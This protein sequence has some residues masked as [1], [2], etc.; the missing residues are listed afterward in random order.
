MKSTTHAET[1]AGKQIFRREDSDHRRRVS[2]MC[3]CKTRPCQ[4]LRYAIAEYIERFYNRQRLHQ[5]LGYRS[6]E[7][8]ERQEGDA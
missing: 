5:A 3:D 6:P 1:L 8:V 2:K 7:E 4:A